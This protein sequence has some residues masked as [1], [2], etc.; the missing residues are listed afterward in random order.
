[1]KRIIITA[2]AAILATAGAQASTI[3]F[4]FTGAS[5]SP[6]I[7]DVEGLVTSVSDLSAVNQG[8]WAT[9]GDVADRGTATGDVFS[10]NTAAG[11][12]TSAGGGWRSGSAVTGAPGDADLSPSSTVNRTAYF[13]F[14]VTP[15]Q[16]VVIESL[17][18]D[19]W[20]PSNTADRGIS[21][22]YNYGGDFNTN[23]REAGWFR[24][25]ST[26]T[27]G[28]QAVNFRFDIESMDG[29]STGNPIEFRFYNINGS[30]NSELRYDNITLNVIP[31]PATAGIMLLA[32]AG[33]GLKRRAM[34]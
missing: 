1:M 3:Q 6:T 17:S 32:L 16:N 15:A 29:T 23:S 24:V 9:T 14:T 11:T 4:E 2:V 25:L 12:G 22:W 27:V 26:T 34:K 5:V 20:K 10:G 8:T 28:A 18:M 13:G 19:F 33:I 31:E 30:T 21:V 7:T